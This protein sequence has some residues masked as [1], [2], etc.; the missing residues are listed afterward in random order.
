MGF[1]CNWLK[2]GAL[3]L[4]LG[5]VCACR[6]PQPR[7]FLAVNE[8]NDRL[9]RTAKP[10]QITERR[11][12]SYLDSV[13]DGGAVTHFFMCVS[14]QRVNFPS[15]TWE[16]IWLG[17]NEPDRSGK[18]NSLWCVNAKALADNGID[19]Y[20]IWIRRCRERNVS[21]WISLRMN[22]YHFV[23]RKAKDCRNEQF[24][25]DHSEWHRVPDAKPGM[26]RPL[27][28]YAWDY[29]HAEVRKHF[30]DLVEEVS[31]R[32]D[33]DGLELDFMRTHECL[34]PG[35]ER[36]DAPV[37]TDFMREVRRIARTA[38]LRRGRSLMVGVRLPTTCAI[39]ES[40]GYDVRAWAKDG[41]VDLVVPSPAYWTPD[42]NMDIAEWRHVFGERVT[43]VPGADIGFSN[44]GVRGWSPDAPW[45][46]QDL[47]LVRGW[48][49][50]YLAQGAAG[51][52]LFNIPYWPSSRR[53]PVYAGELESTN[54]WR[55]SRRYPVMCR[56]VA[57][58]RAEREIQFPKA[59]EKGVSFC[60]TAARGPYDH[61]KV[62]VV[63]GYDRPI[64]PPAV[65]LNAA[66]SIGVGSVVA[67]P[68]RSV[69]SSVKQAHRW[70][71]DAAAFQNGKNV[72]AI[73]GCDVDCQRANIIWCELAV[74]PVAG[75]KLNDELD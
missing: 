3:L 57:Q 41:L 29:R 53:Q 63:I 5:A 37:L 72:V 52:Y 70:E 17:L 28:D 58:T 66:A 33:M 2:P 54:V 30:L 10:E 14:G 7:Q 8:D 6:N 64:E 51:H 34:A 20:A 48:A 46:H 16:P 74:N 1:C 36:E 22:D 44:T 45:F 49:A 39:A 24:F 50:N 65:T 31:A 21:P 25:F 23:N 55:K 35:R 13:L 4:L 47:A 61:G 9:L 68:T 42:Y 15:T 62:S 59:V 40:Y 38:S 12:L 60:V 69:L 73:S 75:L 56:E 32:W 19:L 67:D 11:L 43:I 18:T 27:S 26:N 71:F